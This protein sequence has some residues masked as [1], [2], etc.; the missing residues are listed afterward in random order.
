MLDIGGNKLS[1]LMI[2]HLLRCPSNSNEV[3]LSLNLL[4]NYFVEG[5]DM[6]YCTGNKR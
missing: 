3:C 1:A 5:F 6:H 4:K 2:K